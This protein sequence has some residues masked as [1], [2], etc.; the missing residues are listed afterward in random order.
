MKKRNIRGKKITQ[1]EKNA[2]ADLGEAPLG[3]MGGQIRTPEFA[4][5]RTK[6][7][8]APTQPANQIWAE[9]GAEVESRP[10]DHPRSVT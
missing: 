4:Q 6:T 1:A 3:N 5:R 9:E 7:T 8:P 2:E 10:A